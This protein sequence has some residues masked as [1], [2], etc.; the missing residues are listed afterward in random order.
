MSNRTKDCVTLIKAYN[1]GFK[2][3][4]HQQWAW[5]LK[6]RVKWWYNPKPSKENEKMENLRVHKEWLKRQASS[7]V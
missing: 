4:I 6:E 7:N 1:T 5:K 3:G 2:K